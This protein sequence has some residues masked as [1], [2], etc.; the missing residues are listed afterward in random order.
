MYG[1]M[2]VSYGMFGSM[3]VSYGSMKVS[4]VEGVFVVFMVVCMVV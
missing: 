4:M 3:K 2:K 1:S